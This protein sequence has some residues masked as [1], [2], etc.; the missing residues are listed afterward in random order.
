[1]MTENILAIVQKDG[2]NPFSHQRFL[3]PAG[4]G[5]DATSIGGFIGGGGCKGG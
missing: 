2:K 5:A 3:L 4:W 1:M